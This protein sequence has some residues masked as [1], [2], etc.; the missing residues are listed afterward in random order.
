MTET[1]KCKDVKNGYSPSS[2]TPSGTK[3]PTTTT[4]SVTPKN[5]DSIFTSMK[6]SP[7]YQTYHFKVTVLHHSKP[8]Y[9]SGNPPLP[10][11]LL[12]IHMVPSS[13]PQGILI[14]DLITTHIR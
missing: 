1:S 13:T 4:A 9:G 11:T 5:T 3:A 6:K 7:A 12:R 8:P 2:W 14:Q 10:F